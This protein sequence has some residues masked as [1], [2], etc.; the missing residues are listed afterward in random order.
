MVKPVSVSQVPAHPIE[1]GEFHVIRKRLGHAAGA[2]KIGCSHVELLPGKKSWPLHFH[3]RNEEA[4]F[5]L[6]GEVVLRLDDGDGKFEEHTLRA[7]DYVALPVGPPGHQMINKTDKPARY[8]AFSTMD[9]P[10]IC[11]YP[12]SNKVASYL[13]PPPG[14]D[15]AKRPVYHMHRRA[16]PLDYWDGE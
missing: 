1:H 5:M 7:G 10:E 3:W 4:V 16:K 12:D 11:E 9:S 8:L 13:L 6:E 2:D 14:A 15:P